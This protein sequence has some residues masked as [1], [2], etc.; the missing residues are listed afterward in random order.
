MESMNYLHKAFLLSISIS[1]G[2]GIGMAYLCIN[3]LKVDPLI[4]AILGTIV[5]VISFFIIYDEA[6]E[7]LSPDHVEL[8]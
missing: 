1:I 5:G 3:Y 2:G 8:F 4:A 6:K 7:D